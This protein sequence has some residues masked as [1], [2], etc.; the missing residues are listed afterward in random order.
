MSTVCQLSKT[1]CIFQLVMRPL[2]LFLLFSSFGVLG[3]P[4]RDI[5]FR[6]LYSDD[7][8]FSFH[9]NPVRQG[10]NWKVFYELTLK[11]TLQEDLGRFDIR[12]ETRTSLG[13]KTGEPLAAEAI[14]KR[15]EGKSRLSGTVTVSGNKELSI[16]NA[17]VI[18][19]SRNRSWLFYSFL[20][21]KYPQ[22]RFIVVNNVPQSRRYIKTDSQ[23][24]VQIDSPSVV[25]Y[26]NDNFPAASP[27]Y[28]ESL[29]RVSKAMKVDST[30]T[31]SPS[32]SFTA[33]KPG[34]YLVQTDTMHEHGI[35]FRAEKYYPR[36]ATV[37]SLADPLIYITARQEFERL[38]VAKNEKKAFDKVI[39]SITGDKERAKNLMRS[40]F[41]R[42]EMANQ[43][44]TSYK[45][46]WKT[47]RGMIYIIFGI[48]DE[49]YKFNDR[50]VWS[51]KN[52]QFKS[53][54]EFM[55]SPSLFD[56]E[57]M[58]LIRDKSYRDLTF[59][60]IDLWRN[61]RF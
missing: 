33:D 38:K 39:L 46:G 26:Y 44:F 59:E 13:D 9:L 42:V 14:E 2:L 21:P 52:D 50:E 47:D 29:G 17:N 23:V 58:V 15:S 53:K 37:E 3:Q 4:L 6:Y 7:D 25:S 18:D 57:N 24:S 19:K 51:Y 55:K 27:A 45:E 8:H 12:W 1:L 30:F 36:L 41:R 32:Q 16:I 11:D 49:V 22:D 40:Y 56:P 34:L 20:E 28:A 48:P 10:A 43:F 5:N 31:I 35:A 61:A 54:F 60:V